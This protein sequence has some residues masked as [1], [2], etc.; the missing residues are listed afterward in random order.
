MERLAIGLR[1][2]SLGWPFSGAS[3]DRRASGTA[4]IGSA[5]RLFGFQNVNPGYYQQVRET[6]TP[7]KL[8]LLVGS[9]ILVLSSA[10]GVLRMFPLL[11]PHP[12][13]YVGEYKNRLA[14][15]SISP[16]PQL[17]WKMRPHVSPNHEYNA[18]GFRSLSDFYPNQ[19]CKTIAFAGDS[20]TFGVS[21]KYDKTFPSLVQAGVDGSCA[22]NM[23]IPGFGLDQMWQ[24][25]RTQALP[26]HPKLAVVSFIGGD[27]TRSQYAYDLF[28]GANKPAFK[29]ADGRLVPKT[30]EDNPNFLFRFLENHSSLWR[31]WKLADQTLARFYPHGEWWNLNAA[32]LDAIRED[33]RRDGVPLLFVYIPSHEREV[34]FRSLRA[35]MAN[36]HAS[37]IDLSQGEFTLTP[38][39][40]IPGDGHLNDK[41]HRRVADAVLRWLQTNT[42]LGSG[43]ESMLAAGNPR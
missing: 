13:T 41:G 5:H 17:G 20:F 18:Q 16:D 22:A 30:A 11:R 24:T 21:T 35:Y 31:V 42:A 19:P 6:E 27:L 33:C 7:K 14:W 34:A 9:L 40:Y 23:G 1:A 43:D 28:L 39:M 12:R 32:I 4:R 38:D 8:L 37:F 10:E 26:L 29:L 2:G 36:N 3:E 25:V 15:R